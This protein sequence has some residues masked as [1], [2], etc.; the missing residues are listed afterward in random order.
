MHTRGHGRQAEIRPS[1]A[2]SQSPRACRVTRHTD[3]SAPPAGMYM[4]F[5]SMSVRAAEPC[6]CA[7]GR[8]GGLTCAAATG[9]FRYSAGRGRH[10][11]RTTRKLEPLGT[12]VTLETTSGGL[13]T[14]SVSKNERGCALMPHCSRGGDAPSGCG[15]AKHSA[16]W[17]KKED[18]H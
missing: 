5:E 13:S 3:W 10:P 9:P 4:G 14:S 15:Q 17:G 1:G 8:G 7:R 18:R 12:P 6:H 2:L 11:F 16:R